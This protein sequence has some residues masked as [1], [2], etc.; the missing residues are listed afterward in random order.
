MTK[1]LAAFMMVGSFL[2][3]GNALA[4]TGAKMHQNKQAQLHPRQAQ[5][6][7][8]LK[9]QSSRIKQ[10]AANGSLSHRQAARLNRQDH[11]IYKQE[12]RMKAMNGGNFITKNQRQKLNREENRVSREIR[13]DAGH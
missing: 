2:V 11:A 1:S 3:V 12:Q 5:V 4:E 10:G 9:N 6:N 8:R 13:H 7:G